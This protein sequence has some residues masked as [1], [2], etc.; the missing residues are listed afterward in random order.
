MTTTTP[1]NRLITVGLLLAL[2]GGA[3][4]G[5]ALAVVGGAATGGAAVASNR[6][7]INTQVADEAIELRAGD[8]VN[9][10]LNRRGHIT[11]VSYYRKVLLT[12][13]VA[14]AEDRAAAQAAA[15]GT[16]NVAGV[17]N[18]LA[19]MPESSLGQRSTDTLITS[20]VKSGLLRADGVPGN[21]IKVLTDRSTVY[22]MGRLTERESQLAT[23]VARTVSGVERVVRVIDI[24]SPETALHPNDSAPNT[25][26]PPP[27]PVSNADPA[28]PPAPDDAAVAQ[29]V[30]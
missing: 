8:R 15:A 28:T 16:P 19:V 26:P 10:A 24:V 25:P 4:Q 29:P 9:T 5:C 7:D 3:L 12:G 6:R 27:A 22:L 14:S 13:E 20:K 2:A 17:V 23:E 1:L 18:E 30:R 21:S 11:L